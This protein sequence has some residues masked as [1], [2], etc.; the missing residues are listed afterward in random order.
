MFP[1]PQIAC[2]TSNSLKFSWDIF[3]HMVD[4]NNIMKFKIV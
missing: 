4:E 1:T 2:N 3:T